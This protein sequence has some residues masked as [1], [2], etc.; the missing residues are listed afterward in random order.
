LNRRV[1]HG[2]E[3]LANAEEAR[4]N[5]LLLPPDSASALLLHEQLHQYLV[6]IVHRVNPM[7]TLWARRFGVWAAVAGTSIPAK[8]AV[9]DRGSGNS[10]DGRRF[11]ERRGGRKAWE[12]RR[13]WRRWVE[14][15]E[16]GASAQ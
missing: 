15:G 16:T 7:N 6:V 13:R 12:T 2:Q 1:E 14:G 8:R 11:L 4:Q 10:V 9:A 3:G 5:Q